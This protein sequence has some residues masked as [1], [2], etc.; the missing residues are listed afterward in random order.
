MRVFLDLLLKFR[1]DLLQYA[2]SESAEQDALARLNQLITFVRPPALYFAL[3]RKLYTFPMTLTG[4]L[5]E[6][7]GI[8]MAVWRC[9]HTYSYSS[10][11]RALVEAFNRFLATT[12]LCSKAS[13][14]YVSVI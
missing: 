1:S 10:M 14:T 7:G 13:D 12:L 2:S 5:V 6:D 4:V 9:T 8:V 3:W 11:P